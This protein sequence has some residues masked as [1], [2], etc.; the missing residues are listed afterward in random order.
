MVVR[1]VQSHSYFHLLWIFTWEVTPERNPIVVISVPRASPIHMPLESIRWLTLEKQNRMVVHNVQSHSYVHLLC[2]LTWEFIL[3]RNRIVVLIVRNHSL[4]P[5]TLRVIWR[6]IQERNLIIV[7]SVRNHLLAWM[8]W[9]GTQKFILKG[10]N[11]SVVHCVQVLSEIQQVLR[12]MLGFTRVRNPSCVRCAQNHLII[13]ATSISICEDTGKK[14]YH[15]SECTTS[16]SSN[17][18]HLKI[19]RGEKQ[20]V[21]SKC[22]SSYAFKKNLRNHIKSH[23]VENP[24]SCWE[25]T[26]LIALETDFWQHLKMHADI[27]PLGHTQCSTGLGHLLL[28][29]PWLSTWEF[30]LEISL[31]SVHSVISHFS[32]PICCYTVPSSSHWGVTLHLFTVSQCPKMFVQNTHLQRHFKAH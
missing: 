26:K 10:K 14:P 19:H 7:I 8:I 32:W 6:C 31:I 15:W 18:H 11:R 29:T 20:Y 28:Q 27:K 30:T 17:K 1:N 13:Q 24:F 23:V 2:L 3:A 16:F 9:Q 25:C 22:G 21:F 5:V 12:I 4:C